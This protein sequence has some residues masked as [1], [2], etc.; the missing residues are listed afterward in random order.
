ML[1][2]KY[3]IQVILDR[4]YLKLDKR[5]GVSFVSDCEKS[6][7][8][9]TRT[10]AENYIAN[11]MPGM[12][13]LTSGDVEI[14]EYFSGEQKSAA[15]CPD[16]DVDTAAACL[17]R[18][19]QAISD[20]GDMTFLLRQ[21]NKFYALEMQRIDLTQEDLLHKI[22]FTK[23]GAVEGYKLY[24]RLHE[25]RIR[26]REIKDVMDKLKL[27]ADSNLLGCMEKL[28]QNMAKLDRQCETRIYRPRVLTDLFLPS[29]S[30]APETAPDD[31]P[32]EKLP[33]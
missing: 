2:P 23:A 9:D 14:I 11:N 29:P 21:V 13:G 4:T 20:M 25:L 17:E 7:M 32:P 30:P 8:F 27:I 3:C 24:K 5:C 12:T 33:A 16:L 18:L 6:T 19:M 26:R 28:T 22:E 31:T 10:K 15:E 1:I